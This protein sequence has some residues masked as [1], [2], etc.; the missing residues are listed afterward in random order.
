MSYQE[1][2][3]KL[4][5]ERERINTRCRTIAEQ[6]AEL[7]EEYDSLIQRRLEAQKEINQILQDEIAEAKQ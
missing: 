5:V 2:I 3:D 4:E 7:Q 1:Q 6:K